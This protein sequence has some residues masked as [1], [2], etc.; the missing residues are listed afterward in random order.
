MD[1]ITFRYRYRATSR[2]VRVASV[3]SRGRAHSDPLPILVTLLWGFV[4]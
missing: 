1:P 3:A 4:K 2:G